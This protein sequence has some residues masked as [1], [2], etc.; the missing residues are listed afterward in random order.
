MNDE[1]IYEDYKNEIKEICLKWL[2]NHEI[3]DE[4][5]ELLKVKIRE[6]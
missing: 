1:E 5:L 3:S 2:E 4:Q 6:I